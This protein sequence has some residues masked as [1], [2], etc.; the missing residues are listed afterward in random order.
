MVYNKFWFLVLL[1]D[2]ESEKQESP[3][4]IRW[5]GGERSILATKE[6]AENFSRVSVREIFTMK[7]IFK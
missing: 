2:R 7:N 3:M 4:I 1:M 5:V 6:A